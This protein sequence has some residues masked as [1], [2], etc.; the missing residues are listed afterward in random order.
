[1]GSLRIP[2]FNTNRNVHLLEQV[3]A[4]NVDNNCEY[5]VLRLKKKTGNLF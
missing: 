5:S 2:Y 4:R 3:G 1:M